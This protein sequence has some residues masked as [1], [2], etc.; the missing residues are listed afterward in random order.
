MAYLD[1]FLHGLL[2]IA[3]AWAMLAL[4]FMVFRAKAFGKRELFASAAGSA[5]SGAVYAFTV[6]MLPWAKESIR[7]NLF[8]YAFGIAYHVGIFTAFAYLA[9]YIVNFYHPVICCIPAVFIS[10]VIPMALGCG[11][12][13]GVSLLVKRIVNPVLRG[14]SCPDDYISN[15]LVTAFIAF[16]FTSSLMPRHWVT[17]LWIISA[18]V[19]FAYIPFGKIRHCVFFFI[20]RYHFG[21]FFGRRGCM[22][23]SK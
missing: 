22:P 10:F 17:R 6:G 15:F 18:I 4:L 14:I 1:G 19:L 20:T 23:P 8:S 3:V 13:G 5:V 21:A 11:A 16:A 2:L 12:T 7:E 9:I